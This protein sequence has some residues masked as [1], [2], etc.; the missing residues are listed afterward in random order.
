MFI[1]GCYSTFIALMAWLFGGKYKYS[2]I[3]QYES[4]QWWIDMKRPGKHDMFRPHTVDFVG[5]NHA[6]L[7]DTL[8]KDGPNHILE[9]GCDNCE[10]DGVRVF[11]PPSTGARVTV[12]RGPRTWRRRTSGSRG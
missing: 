1:P 11:A 3:A 2:N 5:V 8:Y 10:L 9:L 7:S 4:E 12:T 6:V